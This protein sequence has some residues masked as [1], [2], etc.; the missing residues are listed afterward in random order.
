MQ[1]TTEE[2]RELVVSRFPGRTRSIAR[3]LE[4]SESFRTLC[5]DLRSCTRALERWRQSD[6]H[7]AP[8]RVS[9][10][11]QCLSELEQEIEEWL[12]NAEP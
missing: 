5:E 2:Y 7:A 3:E 4:R 6:A 12:G 10:Y 8:E 11:E 1:S 9:E